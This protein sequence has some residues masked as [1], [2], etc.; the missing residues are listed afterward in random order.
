MAQMVEIT[1]TDEFNT[2][3]PA[4]RFASATIRLRDGREVTSGATEARGDP[5]HRLPDEAIWHKFDALTLPVLGEQ[6]SA[7]LR[8]CI[9]GLKGADT[10]GPLFELVAPDASA[11]AAVAVNA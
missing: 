11:P 5:E 8:D 2:A 10:S 6:R 7:A 9:A 4:R 1:E 3:F